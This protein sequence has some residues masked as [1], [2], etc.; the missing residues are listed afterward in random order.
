MVGDKVFLK[1]KGNQ[2]MTVDLLKYTAV[3]SHSIDEIK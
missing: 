1:N 2:L 3:A